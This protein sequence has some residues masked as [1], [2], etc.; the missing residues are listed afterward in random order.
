M[1]SHVVH[2]TPCTWLTRSLN[3]PTTPHPLERTTR[4]TAL[5]VVHRSPDRPPRRLYRRRSA[6]NRLSCARPRAHLAPSPARIVL[7]RTHRT[8]APPPTTA[9]E[10]DRPARPSVPSRALS[11]PPR[12]SSSASQPSRASS[13]RPRSSP[14]RSRT[15][16]SDRS[17]R[18]AQARV[19]RGRSS[20]ARACPSRP[21][22]PPSTRCVLPQ[23]RGRAGLSKKDKLT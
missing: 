1:A 21:R 12:P 14:T 23:P 18:L 15:S 9:R 4:A 6:Y 13:R 19:P 16:T 3:P 11:R 17:C 22:P 8:T 5:A 20:S 2:S 7:V 10:P